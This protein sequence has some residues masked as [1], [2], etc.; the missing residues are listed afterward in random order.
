MSR[1]FK[2]VSVFTEYRKS[3]RLSKRMASKAVRRQDAV[4][5]GGQFKRCFQSYDI[6]DYRFYQGVKSRW[7]HKGLRK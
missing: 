4:A 2:R 7:Y 3:K 1:S 6:C 5:D